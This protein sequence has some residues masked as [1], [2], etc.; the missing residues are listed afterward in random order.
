[1]LQIFPYNQNRCFEAIACLSEKSL[2]HSSFVLLFAF[3]EL[4][5]Q[6]EWAAQCGECIEVDFCFQSNSKHFKVLQILKFSTISM[7]SPND[8]VCNV[9]FAQ[10]PYRRM[11][12]IVQNNFCRSYEHFSTILQ[13]PY[14]ISLFSLSLALTHLKRIYY[15]ISNTFKQYHFG[16]S[17]YG[18]Y[19]CIIA[20][21]TQLNPTI[22]SYESIKFMMEELQHP[23]SS[24][25]KKIGAR[26]KKRVSKIESNTKYINMKISLCTE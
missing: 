9:G 4:L 11:F 16:I 1:M 18:N 17:R 26:R 19:V 21:K 3:L 12:F 8:Y 23:W 7:E 24:A 6:F 20:K 13:V 2:F 14:Y 22:Y 5:F 15:S 10:E 25:S